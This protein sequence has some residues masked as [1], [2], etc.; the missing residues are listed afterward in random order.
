[1]Q[2]L[3]VN[4]E[5]NIPSTLRELPPNIMGTSRKL[6]ENFQVVTGASCLH[7]QDKCNEPEDCDDEEEEPCG[8]VESAGVDRVQHHSADD[9]TDDVSAGRHAQHRTC[10]PSLAYS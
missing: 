1:M 5:E 6:Y 7:E 2:E 8:D 10:A 3:P 9:L 4:F